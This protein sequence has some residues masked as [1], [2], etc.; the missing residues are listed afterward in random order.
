MIM[1]RAHLLEIRKLQLTVKNPVYEGVD[2][3]VEN[4][5]KFTYST[6]TCNSILP[7]RRRGGRFACVMAVGF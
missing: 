1:R 3:Y 4:A 2:F 6:S 7:G 5:L